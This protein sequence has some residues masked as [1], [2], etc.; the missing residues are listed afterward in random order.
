MLS[1]FSTEVP[2]LPRSG[3][4]SCSIV[5]GEVVMIHMAEAVT[6]KSPSGNLMVDPL[7]LQPMSRLGGITYGA[8]TEVI[9][10]PRPNSQGQY[11]KQA[12]V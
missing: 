5:I 1:L 9:D 6:S 7:K 3:K 2:E 11:P 8:T 4:L 12:K 10:L